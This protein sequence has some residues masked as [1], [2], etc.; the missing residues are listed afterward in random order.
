M[1]VNILKRKKKFA[2]EGKGK[3]ADYVHKD[4][5]IFMIKF[6]NLITLNCIFCCLILFAKTVITLAIF[7][8]FSP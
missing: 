3:R 5:D 8:Y 1:R 2:G 4:R 7:I 6:Y